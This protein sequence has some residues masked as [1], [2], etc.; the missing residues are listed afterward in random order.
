M[1]QGGGG[2]EEREREEMEGKG[3]AEKGKG[4]GNELQGG[5]YMQ[6]YQRMKTQGGRIANDQRGD[7]LYTYTHEE[8]IQ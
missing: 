1:G 6:A 4:R 2:G 5:V 7:G 8:E 3:E